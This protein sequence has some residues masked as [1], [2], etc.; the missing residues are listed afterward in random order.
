VCGAQ[1]ALLVGQPKVKGGCVRQK[2]FP[3]LRVGVDVAE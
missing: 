1:D 2:Q 3:Y